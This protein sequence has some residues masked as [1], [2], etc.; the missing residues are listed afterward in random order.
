MSKKV[1]GDEGDILTIVGSFCHHPLK[2]AAFIMLF[3][4]P[5]PLAVGTF[6]VQFLP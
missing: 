3:L 1:I 6:I 4:I 5:N 2:P